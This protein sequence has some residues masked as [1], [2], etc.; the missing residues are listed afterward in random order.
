MAH[1]RSSTVKYEVSDLVCHCAFSQV[2]GP[3]F[4]VFDTVV[5]V[6]SSIFWVKFFRWIYWRRRRNTEFLGYFLGN[7]VCFLYAEHFVTLK[8]RGQEQNLSSR[9]EQGRYRSGQ[10]QL[11][12]LDQKLRENKLSAR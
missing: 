8:G 12:V 2:F 4:Y 3:D 9:H 1:A 7:F 11:K 10:F 6:G 5:E